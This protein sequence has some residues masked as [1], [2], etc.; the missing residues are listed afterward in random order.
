MTESLSITND[1]FHDL[2][3][4][5]LAILPHDKT[6]CDMMQNWDVSRVTDCSLLF[7]EELMDQ[8]A[9]KLS[10]GAEWFNVDLSA[11]NT[12]SCTTMH[13][14]F[15]GASVFN[16]PLDSWDVSNV[17]DMARM[18]QNAKQFHPDSLSRWNTAQVTDMSHMFRYAESFA[19]IQP[20]LWNVERVRSF[21]YMFHNALDF[22]NPG[23]ATWQ[24]TGARDDDDDDVTNQQESTS[25]NVDRLWA[26]KSMFDG[27]ISFNVDVSSWDISGAKSLAFMFHVRMYTEK[28]ELHNVKKI[29]SILKISKQFI[30][31]FVRWY[32]SE[33]MFTIYT[34]IL[35]SP[36]VVV[37]ERT[38]L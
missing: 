10:V 24:V 3:R 9:W 23:L 32:S 5:C 4:D 15:H 37:S 19:P 14:M 2:I 11:W 33:T 34:I 7:W 22:N 8:N 31:L 16:Q 28:K 6:A 36:L 20:L 25:S 35:C 13:G 27:A 12:S 26:F 30:V 21:Q 38:C 29:V 1:N 18:F 17:M